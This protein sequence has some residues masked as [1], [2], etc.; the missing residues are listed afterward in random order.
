MA[1]NDV[2]WRLGN[3]KTI[4][5]EGSTVENSDGTWR[6]GNL[7]FTHDF[8]V[9][10]Y[11]AKT[12]VVKGQGTGADASDNNGGGYSSNSTLSGFQ[13]TNGGA[14][15]TI[16]GADYDSLT[17]KITKTG[18][19]AIN[20]KGIWANVSGNLSGRYWIQDSDANSITIGSGLGNNSGLTIYVG[21]ALKT[22]EK[23]L[24]S[25]VLRPGDT[26]DL[27]SMS[28]TYT[29]AT[30]GGVTLKFPMASGGGGSIFGRGILS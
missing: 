3:S 30:G 10:S 2:I 6:Y 14:K 25:I 27:S 13:D 5:S 17:G 20:L 9:P 26:I 19:F 12:L 21:G 24:D 8:I 7:L 23:S 22:I 4:Q 16:I 28:T 29:T 18:E 1:V 11:P 15:Y